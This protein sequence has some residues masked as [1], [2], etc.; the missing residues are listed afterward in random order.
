M[1][2]K[3]NIAIV[4]N[5]SSEITV[6]GNFDSG[7]DV[8]VSTRRRGFESSLKKLDKFGKCLRVETDNGSINRKIP[9][10]LVKMH[11]DVQYKEIN[12]FRDLNI[13]NTNEVNR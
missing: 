2:N 12:D 10:L 1:D 6:S 13:F 4:I 9:V 8:S 3:L 7:E 11:V 5:D